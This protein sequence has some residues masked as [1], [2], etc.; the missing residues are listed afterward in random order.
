MLLTG[1]AWASKLASSSA[2]FP[3]LWPLCCRRP[4]SPRLDRFGPCAPS[5]PLSCA[6]PSAASPRPANAKRLDPTP[7]RSGASP[8]G[9]A[10]AKQLDD[11]QSDAE[12]P[13][14]E[15]S[16]IR[17]TSPNPSSCPPGAS[18]VG[19]RAPS[20]PQVQSP[21][22]ARQEPRLVAGERHPVHKL[23]RACRALGHRRSSARP[24][25]ARP[26]PLRVQARQEPRPRPGRPVSALMVR[27]RTTPTAGKR[28]PKRQGRQEPR[29][30]RPRL[31]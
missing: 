21:A 26:Q 12:P 9:P 22:H 11:P 28:R 19:R 16:A 3:R 30:R 2:N 25:A 17:S 10:S 23:W 15:S 20:G 6:M 8:T 18:P 29:P 27:S 14:G 13:H 1:R 4:F 24:S 31:R 7:R 5:W